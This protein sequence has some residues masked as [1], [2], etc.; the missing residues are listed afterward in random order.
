MSAIHQTDIKAALQPIW[1]SK[2]P[3]AIK[4][5]RRTMIVFNEAKGVGVPCD[6]FVVEAAKR[7]LGIVRHEPTHIVATP[8]QEIPALY[9]RLRTDISSHLCLRWMILTLVRADGC[10]GAR[11]SEIDGDVW[12]VPADRVKGMEGAVTDF[13]VP[14]S[15]EALLIPDAA[16]SFGLDLMFPGRGDRALSSTALEKAL[17]EMDEAGRPHGFRSSFRDWV[18]DIEAASYEVAET[19]LGHKI[20]SRVV[21]AYAR[22]DLLER[23]RH[24]MEAWARFVTG[25]AQNVVSLKG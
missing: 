19:I 20:G 16:R 11:V 12:T 18:Q 7:M 21:R 25:H 17:N 13:R 14:L 9:A 15:A 5:L 1:R 3:T 2:Q 4:A 22:S 24:V 10:K 23:R 8:W 6:P